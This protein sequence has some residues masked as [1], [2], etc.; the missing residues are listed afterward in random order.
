[1]VKFLDL[2]L[3]LDQ[4]IKKPKHIQSWVFYCLKFSI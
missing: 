4:D 3:T 1:M 2:V